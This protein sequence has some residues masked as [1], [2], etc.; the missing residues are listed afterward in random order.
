M[1]SVRQGYINSLQRVVR[2]FEPASEW[3]H[4]TLKDIPAV[5]DAINELR[6][7]EPQEIKAPATPSSASAGGA[8][9][10]TVGTGGEMT[11]RRAH[12]I[13]NG[14]ILPPRESYNYSP[15]SSAPN[16]PR[17]SGQSGADFEAGSLGPSG[18]TG[19]GRGRT[20]AVQ[21]LSPEQEAYMVDQ[22]DPQHPEGLFR[23]NFIN[24]AKH[25]GIYYTEEHRALT[26]RNMLRGSKII[27]VRYEGGI[28]PR[29]NVDPTQPTN[30][31]P[32][33]P[34]TPNAAPPDTPSAAPVAAAPAGDAMDTSA[35]NE[36]N[37]AAAADATAPAMSDVPAASAAVSAPAP[38]DA[39]TAVPSTPTAATADASASDADAVY[40]DD[41]TPFEVVDQSDTSP[42]VSWRRVR[43]VAFVPSPGSKRPVSFMYER[44][45]EGML[46][47]VRI[48]ESFL[49][50]RPPVLTEQT[51][52]LTAADVELS[53][54]LWLK[55]KKH[56]GPYELEWFLL[57]QIGRNKVSSL[58]STLASGLG[59]AA[60]FCNSS[61][62]H[63]PKR[64]IVLSTEELESLREENAR[65]LYGVPTRE[66]NA[67]T[68]Q[69][70]MA[71]A[72]AEQ[73][74]ANDGAGVSVGGGVQE[75]DHSSFQT[76]PAPSRPQRTKAETVTHSNSASAL[77]P[78]Q[79]D[80][81]ALFQQPS[82]PQ[83]QQQLQTQP[84]YSPMAPFMP[85]MQA[86]TGLPSFPSSNRSFFPSQ[87]DPSS[88]HMER[89]RQAL[90]QIDGANQRQQLQR[91]QNPDVAPLLSPNHL[92]APGIALSQA[93]SSLLSP[94]SFP[95][96]MPHGST[97]PQLPVAAPSMV[98]APASVESV[99]SLLLFI[100]KFQ[101]QLSTLSSYA[102]E[103][104]KSVD[105]LRGMSAQLKVE[106]SAALKVQQQAAK[107]AEQFQQIEEQKFLIEQL[108]AEKNGAMKPNDGAAAAQPS[109]A[110]DAP[111]SVPV[112]RAADPP[113]LPVDQ[114][115]NDAAVTASTVAAATFPL[116]PLVDNKQTELQSNSADAGGDE[117]KE[118]AQSSAMQI[119]GDDDD[120]ELPPLVTADAPIELPSSTA[121]AVTPATDDAPIAVDA[122]VAAS[123]SSLT[124]TKHAASTR[125]N[126]QDTTL[127]Q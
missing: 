99:P 55:C 62:A 50:H 43:F 39:A 13:A 80:C 52:G 51:P 56:F 25:F 9:T 32:A 45:W 33:E 47:P 3:G 82:Q 70:L 38:S 34:A 90:Q 105:A 72:A 71:A 111:S 40:A 75:Q 58:I 107:I 41:D 12:R 21:K 104:Q 11:T 46:C 73:T 122:A 108:R 121:A 48:Y 86:P 117:R 65:H 115:A 59:F 24:V 112:A 42:A 120:D 22:L 66:E 125:F 118:D 61:I 6:S 15:P 35:S 95:P 4:L 77:P 102:A 116:A 68:Q 98:L 84:S 30:A 101:T 89:N 36:S 69:A 92:A 88:D 113:S 127:L 18:G 126:D 106:A 123:P 76:R 8:S 49:S 100:D 29:H 31:T 57:A 14:E 74:N 119:D 97:A 16:S 54:V 60:G 91:Q 20:S 103:C 94:F 10:P 5:R 64:P 19:V 93:S 27:K 81:S 37:V 109:G 83:Q 96:L 23:L 1:Q 44:P 85:F 79:F 78:M 63:A 67:V 2:T 7:R 114:G 53:Y 110:A 28:K 17:H 87:L 26:I 124:P